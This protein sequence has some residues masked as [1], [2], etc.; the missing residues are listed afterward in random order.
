MGV[1]Y[2]YSGW[3]R[4]DD[5]NTLGSA[6]LYLRLG[7]HG[8]T[9]LYLDGGTRELTAPMLRQLRLVRYQAQAMT[10]PDL[11]L[12][13]SSLR[14]APDPEV[15]RAVQA[16]FPDEPR[17]SEER[18]RERFTLRPPTQG[19]TATFLADVARAYTDAVAAGEKP[20]VALVEQTGHEK[21]TVERW[22][23]LARKAGHDMPRWRAP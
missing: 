7:E 3:V 14:G 1:T 21:R 19:L 17:R 15:R 18:E 16:A 13:M 10:R 20:N 2:G 11:M 12:A 6:T 23:Y 8:V 5:P 4:V 9:E 22:V